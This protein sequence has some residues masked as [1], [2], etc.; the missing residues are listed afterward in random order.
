MTAT[1]APRLIAER[2]PD[3]RLP[4]ARLLDRDSATALHPP[5]DC[6]VIAVAGRIDGRRVIAYCTD[7]TKMGGALGA[8]G[9]RR[10]LPA[11]SAAR[12][13]SAWWTR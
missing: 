4:V 10:V 12:S 9:V 3:P 2:A 6:G 8:A 5:D 11:E 7:A 1:A 13:T